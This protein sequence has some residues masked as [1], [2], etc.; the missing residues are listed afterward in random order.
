MN[1][2]KTIFSLRILK[3]IIDTF[4]DTFFVLYFLS[5][6][7]ENIVPLGIYY[8][9]QVIAIYLVFY[10]CRNIMRT[11]RRINL[12]RIA[13]G[14]DVVYFLL[15]IILQTKIASFPYILGLLRGLEEGFYYSV[16]N[17]IESDGIK[18]TQ[19]GKFNGVY[20]MIAAAFSVI[21]PLL[22]GNFIA[23]TGFIQS[24]LVVLVIV[25]VR[26]LLSFVYR[27]HNLPRSD[28]VNMHKYHEVVKKDQRFRQTNLLR[29][30]Q[31]LVVSCSAFA[32]IVAIYTVRF[33]PDSVSFGVFTAVFAAVSGLI[34]ITFAKFPRFYNA[35]TIVFCTIC[36]TLAMVWM[37]FDCNVLSVILFK[38][39]RIV[40][41]DGT[42]ILN[43]TSTS[44]LSNDAKIRRE[45]KTEFL[46]ESEKYLML[47][48][49]AGYLLFISMA[50]M[51]SWTPILLAFAILQVL[52]VIVVIRF[53]HAMARRGRQRASHRRHLLPAFRFV[54]K[55]DLE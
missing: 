37:I 15:I 38:F 6:S 4:I 23:E 36:A 14:L 27:D 46:V 40:L 16:Y 51:E 43:D 7:S 18:N 24:L 49:V 28:K 26:I 1:N 41:K 50:F 20:K 11:K 8:I 21:L 34:G 13:M 55:D 45:Y 47:G 35:K 5:V 3:N 42:Q 22:F 32:S 30:M 25:A 44:N 33:F 54:E 2:Y 31:G 10:F 39:W 48:R 9:I 19:R 52:Y 29:F 12:M 53:N 17:V